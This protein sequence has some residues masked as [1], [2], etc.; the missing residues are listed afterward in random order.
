MDGDDSRQ[1]KN[2]KISSTN[3]SVKERAGSNKSQSHA[4]KQPH[5]YDPLSLPDIL[6]DLGNDIALACTTI[7][8]DCVAMSFKECTDGLLCGND[9]NRQEMDL[10]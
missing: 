3:T 2:N 9:D 6:S 7:R 10:P 8:S 1:T 5:P 4:K